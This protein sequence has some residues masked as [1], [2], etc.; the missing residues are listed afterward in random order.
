MKLYEE[1]LLDLQEAGIRSAFVSGA[2]NELKN[3]MK[4][5]QLKTQLKWSAGITLGIPAA[6][7]IFKAVRAQLSSAHR[8]CG[9]QGSGP[10]YQICVNREK[11]KIFRDALQKLVIA[12]SKCSDNTKCQHSI[13]S[14]ITSVRQKLLMFQRELE[15]AQSAVKA[16]KAE[17]Q[18]Y[19]NVNELSIAGGATKLAGGTGSLAVQI[20]AFSV[21]DKLMNPI[22]QKIKEA[23]SKVERQCISFDEGP[24]RDICKARFKMMELQK[25][26]PELNRIVNLCNSKTH[27]DKKCLKYA[28]KLNQVKEQ[29][30]VF[31]DN[32]EIYRQALR[33]QFAQKTETE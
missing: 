32:I 1:K 11:I 33:N 18:K 14:K 2:K 27:G 31:Q 19:E 8:R 20:V 7:A 22:F 9:S 6:I 17:N 24:A 5:E 3:F 23:F 10:G 29:I 25:Q 13:D 26:L 15:E 21:F 30:K 16:A 28:E 4:P 12:R